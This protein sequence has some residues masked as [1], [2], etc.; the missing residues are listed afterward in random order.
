MLYWKLSG[1]SAYFMQ[2]RAKY[3][4]HSWVHGKHSS[5]IKGRDYQR[6]P[7]TEKVW[8]QLEH[9][10]IYFSFLERDIQYFMISVCKATRFLSSS[11]EILSWLQAGKNKKERIWMKI[12]SEQKIGSRVQLLFLP[13]CRRCYCIL[14]VSLLK[15]QL[16][17]TNPQTIP[18]L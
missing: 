18:I 7:D 8:L 3:F 15:D 9:S 1:N 5:I 17:K 4:S 10:G 11:A 6:C 12:I 16:D 13:S 2:L 14:K